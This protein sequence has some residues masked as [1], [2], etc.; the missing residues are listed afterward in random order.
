MDTT[1][2]VTRSKSSTRKDVEAHATNAVSADPPPQSRQDR[3]EGNDLSGKDTSSNQQ[4]STWIHRHVIA[5]LL[6]GVPYLLESSH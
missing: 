6:L 5:V 2:K 3:S 1:Q 4:T